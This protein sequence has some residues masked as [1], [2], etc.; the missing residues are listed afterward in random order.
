MFISLRALTGACFLLVAPLGAMAGEG[1]LTLESAQRLALARSRSLP[2]QDYAVAAARDLA[3]AAGQLPDPVLK[4]G[5]DNLPVSGADRYALGADFMTMRRV[6]VSQELTSADKR[7]WR[8]ERYEAEAARNLAMKRSIAATVERDAA[9]A[10]L[11]LHFARESDRLLET[12]EAG[13]KQEV[14]ASRSA[15]RGGRASLADT[16][17]AELAVA[18]IAE[19]RIE[20]ARRVQVALSAL[21]RWVGAA[22]AGELGPLPDIGMSAE[23]DIASHPHLAALRGQ[24]QVARAETSLAKAGRKQDWTV[25]VAFQQRGSAYSNM[26]S[27]GVSVP[28]QW[29]RDKR[30]NREIAAR[31]SQE[32]QAEAEVEEAEREFAAAAQAQQAEWRAAAARTKQYRET[33]LPLA[34]RRQA[35]ALAEYRGGKA[36]LADVLAARRAE[37]DSRLQA[38]DSEAALAKAWVQLNYFKAGAQQ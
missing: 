20:S 26:V 18:Q 9:L 28:L 37:L 38:L 14:E 12:L 36:T 33:S 34:Q 6:G 1:P 29:D 35:A 5:I 17:A 15:H 27:F 31:Q 8:A 32:L 16:V 3:V 13:A 11:E 23:A 7:H 19:R 4:A 22:K 2:A 10:W 21:E 25:E 30:Q 24:E